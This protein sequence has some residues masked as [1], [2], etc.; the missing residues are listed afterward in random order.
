VNETLLRFAKKYGVKYFAANESFYIDK[1]ESNAHDVLLCIKEGEFKSTPIGYGR[2]TRFGLSN[3]EYYFKS[4]EEMKSIFRDLPEAIEAVGEIIDKIESYTLERN[5][6]LPKFDIPKEFNT[7]DEYLRHLTYKGAQKK[8]GEI[9]QSLRERLDFELDTIQKTGYPGYFLIVQDLLLRPV[10]LECLLAQDAGQQQ[11]PPLPIVLV[12]PMSILLNTICCSN[13]F[14][15]PDRVSLPDIDID[16]DDEGRDKVL[17]YV[18]DKYGKKPGRPDYNL[19]HYGR[20]VVHPRLCQSNGVTPGGCK[21]T[22]EDGSGKTRYF[23]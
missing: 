2:G 11:D 4:Q 14:L 7:E 1:E 8:Y 6:V 10:K 19:W 5:V 23:A 20:Q 17:K 15:N 22:G 16:F 9:S 12:S 21:L 13:V 18:I 3:S